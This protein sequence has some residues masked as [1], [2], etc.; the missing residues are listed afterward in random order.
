MAR[1]EKE[2]GPSC[3]HLCLNFSETVNSTEVALKVKKMRDEVR[4]QC[5]FNNWLNL[6]FNQT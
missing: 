5:V 4:G 1:A 3:S 6:L 2:Q